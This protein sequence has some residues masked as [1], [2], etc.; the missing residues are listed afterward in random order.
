M[1]WWIWSLWTVF[2]EQIILQKFCWLDWRHLAG[3]KAHRHFSQIPTEKCAGAGQRVLVSKHLPRGL[4]S[5]DKSRGFNPGRRLSVF[6]CTFTRWGSRINLYIPSSLWSIVPGWPY[7]EYHEYL[8]NRAYYVLIVYKKTQCGPHLHKWYVSCL[9][10][11]RMVHSSE[12][13]SEPFCLLFVTLIVK[14]TQQKS[15]LCTIL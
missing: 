8:E 5:R 14:K 3:G 13:L 1:R 6:I 9:I 12:S 10:D 15:F 4:C 7:H 2:D 11:E